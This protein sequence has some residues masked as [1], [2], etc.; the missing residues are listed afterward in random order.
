MHHQHLIL[1]AMGFALLAALAGSFATF[2]A[3]FL[4]GIFGAL[5]G[6]LPWAVFGAVLVRSVLPREEA[7]DGRVAAGFF[8]GGALSAWMGVEGIAQA[9]VV[10]LAGALGLALAM[11]VANAE[12]LRFG[13][14]AA[15]ALVAG[16]ALAGG[17]PTPRGPT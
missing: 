3:G 13:G 5:A 15:V 17:L 9:L 11:P 7:V 6:G 16:G 12:R 8:A 14:A 4:A 10:G 1:K 2:P